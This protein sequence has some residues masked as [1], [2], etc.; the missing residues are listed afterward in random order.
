M[1]WNGLILI[2]AP[3]YMVGGESCGKLH[4]VVVDPHAKQVADLIVERGFLRKTDRVLP[5]SVVERTGDLGKLDHVLVNSRSGQMTHLV[6]RT[7]LIP[8]YRVIP[9][10]MVQDVTE[11]SVFLSALLYP[12]GTQ[13]DHRES[14][15]VGDQVRAL[16]CIPLLILCGETLNNSL[17]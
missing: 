9:I 4:K 3:R 13:A 8:E 6:V 10:D 17:V 7:G 12:S 11:T 2:S 15:C 5:V 1:Q 16:E 14:G